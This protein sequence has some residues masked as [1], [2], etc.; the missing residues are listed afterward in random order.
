MLTQ[1]VCALL[2]SPIRRPL[3]GSNNKMLCPSQAAANKDPSGEKSKLN[4][5]PWCVESTVFCGSHLWTAFNEEYRPP[6]KLLA[7]KLENLCPSSLFFS[8]NKGVNLASLHVILPC[9]HLCFWDYRLCEEK[10]EDNIK[11][12]VS[13]MVNRGKCRCNNFSISFIEKLL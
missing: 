12:H 9:L 10:D 11:H 1:S 13:Q 3:K 5:P 8:Q 4:I 2:F 7:S 6:R